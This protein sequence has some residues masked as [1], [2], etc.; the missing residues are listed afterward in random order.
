MDYKYENVESSGNY[1]YNYN[2]NY[3]IIFSSIFCILLIIIALAVYYIISKNTTTDTNTVTNS[4]PIATNVRGLTEIP[5]LT[6]YLTTAG[7]ILIP[8][9]PATVNGIIVS[10]PLADNQPFIYLAPDTSLLE[11]E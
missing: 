8:I 3:I 9:P 2:Y 7:N 11:T 10:D 1:N 5:V 6:Q 4:N